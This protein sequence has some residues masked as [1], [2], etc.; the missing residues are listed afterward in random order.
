MGGQERERWWRNREDEPEG[1]GQRHR[2]K[3]QGH[4]EVRVRGAWG[5][6]GWV[7]GGLGAGER[8]ECESRRQRERIL[9]HLNL[10]YRSSNKAGEGAT[11]VI[12][13]TC[14]QENILSK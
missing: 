12:F 3:R 4:R 9:S 1:G 8:R 7:E 6:R 2:M 5:W 11:A 10:A 13:Q 14:I